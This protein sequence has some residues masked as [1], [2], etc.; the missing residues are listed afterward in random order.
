MA[1][2]QALNVV[3]TGASR[4]IGLELTRQALARGHRLFV[5]CRNP[6]QASDLYQMRYRYEGKLTIMELDV[7]SERSVKN[8]AEGLGSAAI[9]ILI[10]NAGVYLDRDARAATISP[11]AMQETFDTNVLGPLRVSQAVLPYLRRA[12]SPKLVNIT[13]LMGSIADNSS[14]GSLAYRSSK[15]A[16]NMFTKNLAREEK[17]ITVLSLH[18]GWVKTEMG[19]DNAPL[20]TQA[21]AEGILDV[22]T[23]SGEADSGKFFNYSGKE[24]PW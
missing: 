6:G 20:T 18:P 14:G 10:N 3:I 2:S 12:A 11:A 24:L 17:G 23:R 21:S 4:G 8:F 22:V 5:G 1:E 13:S 9:D 15:A 19:G 7:T 16:L